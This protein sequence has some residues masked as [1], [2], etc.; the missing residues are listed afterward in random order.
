MGVHAQR[1]LESGSG[2]VIAVWRR[3]FY[4]RFG[5]KL[6]C[7]GGRPIGEGPLNLILENAPSIDW[8]ECLDL[9]QSARA[10]G[11]ALL[12]GLHQPIG[13]ANA[14]LWLPPPV[15]T[16][17]RESIIAGL[18]H[19]DRITK[20]WPVPQ[21][22]LACFVRAD[23]DCSHPIAMAA[24]P[25][26]RALESWLR[27]AHFN[28]PPAR[29]RVLLGLGPG[30]TPSGDDFLAAALATL[31]AIDAVNV[32][33]ALWQVLEAGLDRTNEISA[34][35]LRCA[36]TGAIGAKQHALLNAIL[37]GAEDGIAQAVRPILL[38]VHSSDRDG[39]AGMTTILHAMF[40][41]RDR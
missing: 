21:E 2:E 3:S 4:L 7:A 12:I 13:L 39:M 27:N 1:A 40:G 30:L 24:K 38:S 28:H 35:H 8:Q 29:L 37:Y 5:E 16:W 15:P 23:C 34:A 19:L 9:G 18:G 11:D 6:I 17:S 10:E 26:I 41:E 22:G 20:Y 14:A 33:N 32:A 25:S 31:H 36:A